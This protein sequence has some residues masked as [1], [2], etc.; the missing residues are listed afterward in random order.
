MKLFR[1]STILL[2]TLM[3]VMALSFSSVAQAQYDE[4]QTSVIIDIT[5]GVTKYNIAV[6]DLVALEGGG[7][8]GSD[9]QK[10]PQR[11]RANLDMVGIFN[12]LDPR[13]FLDADPRSGIDGNIPLTFASWSQ[14]GANYVVKGG[15]EERGSKI[16]LEMRLF[17]VAQGRQILGKRYSGAAKDGRKMINQFTNALLEAITGTPGVFGSKIIF[18]TGDKSNR[19]IMMTEL[20]SDEVESLAGSKNGPSSQP[21][22][23]PGN[24][25][26]WIHRN[27]KQYE[28]LVDGKVISSGE[29]HLSPAFM[30]DGTVAAAVSGPTST[31]IFSIAGKKSKTPLTQVGSIAISPSFSPD[32]RMV[33]A[34][35]QGGSVQLYINGARLTT[36]SKS[37][38]P[39]WSPKGDWIAFV[40][41]ETDVC[42]VSPSSG[43]MYQ[44]TGGQGVNLR[45][46]FS[47]D[48][49]MI[50]FSS[51]RNGKPQL[52]VMGAN[53]QNPTPI[54]PDY[55][56]SQYTPY[57]SPEMPE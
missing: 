46:S 17:D 56:G 55:A 9:G 45:P 14:I 41:R 50:V 13:S 12:N 3:A 18:V 21:T 42:I 37:T 16:T 8:V 49:R 54:L 6:N 27:G 34:S 19:S 57:W 33:Y 28:L 7:S 26:A 5:K 39:A 15:I 1:Q 23:G 40:S 47:P 31:N 38:D 4:S 35:D 51:T 22:M 48:G 24:K 52:F 30:P 32:G 53:G 36:A 29:L 10:L 44:L 2:L 43:Q 20:G 25:T 11:L